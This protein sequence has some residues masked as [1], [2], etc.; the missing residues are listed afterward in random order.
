MNS[1]ARSFAKILTQFLR[2]KSWSFEF[3]I[4]LF[5]DLGNCQLQD[6]ASESFTVPSFGPFGLSSEKSI[7][8]TIFERFTTSVYNFSWHL[9]L[10]LS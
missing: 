4:R 10:G 1:N 9:V 2:V 6:E 3:R 5:E 8:G 7:E